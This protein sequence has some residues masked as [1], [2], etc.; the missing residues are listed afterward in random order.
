M[1]WTTGAGTARVWLLDLLIREFQPGDS[2]VQTDCDSLQDVMAQAYVRQQERRV[3]LINKR[4]TPQTVRLPGAQ[5]GTLLTVD[6]A[7][8]EKPARLEKL[9][10]DSIGLQP[11]AVS[12]VRMPASHSAH[13]L[14]QAQ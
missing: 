13:W 10:S 4:S 6:E 2:L 8:G 1:N 12:V 14:Q 11:F 5:G 7:S 9:S 3:L